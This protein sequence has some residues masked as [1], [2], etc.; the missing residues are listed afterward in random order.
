MILKELTFNPKCSKKISSYYP[1][2]M[3]LMRPKEFTL[4]PDH[5]VLQGCTYSKDSIPELSRKLTYEKL[6]VSNGSYV[7]TKSF[8]AA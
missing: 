2:I 6:F 7:K 3:V 8:Q 4:Y 1:Y 5:E